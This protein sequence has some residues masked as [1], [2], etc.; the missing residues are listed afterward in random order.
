LKSLINGSTIVSMG[1]GSLVPTVAAVLVVSGC[2]GS[3]RESSDSASERE[4]W[5]RAVVVYN[6]PAFGR[7]IQLV[8]SDGRR[9]RIV[10]HPPLP[11][12]GAWS[13]DGTRIA[14]SGAEGPSYAL[15]SRNIYTTNP[16]GTDVRL[17]YAVPGRNKT[18][19]AFPFV[20]TWSPDG[21][22]LA[23]ADDRGGPWI[24]GADGRGARRLAHLAVE[25]KL[26]DRVVAG[27]SNARGRGSRS[28]GQS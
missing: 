9:L 3:T 26:L 1:R 18:H 4:K 21:K 12:D 13:P 17:V 23:F 16:A 5:V 27:R 10:P 11:I 20:P 8:R 22:W 28:E 2:S 24:V 25:S 19:A 15:G 6:T 7:E 14:F